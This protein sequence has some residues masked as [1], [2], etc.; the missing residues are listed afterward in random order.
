M[1]LFVELPGFA[2]GGR[3]IETSGEME[4]GVMTSEKGQTATP[5]GWLME[6]V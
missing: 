1:E 6:T 5:P 3:S 2:D 4:M